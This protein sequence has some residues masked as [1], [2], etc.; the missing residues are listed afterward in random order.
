MARSN[1]IFF[2]FALSW[3]RRRKLRRDR[4]RNPDLKRPRGY[5]MWRLS[6][7]GPF[8]HALYGRYS[9]CGMVRVVSY[10]PRSPKKRLVPPPMFEG[11]VT[12]GD[13]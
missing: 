4:K 8:P 6:D 7:W 11:K 3:R 2:A 12:W 1:C 5:V 13:N 10:K 9:A